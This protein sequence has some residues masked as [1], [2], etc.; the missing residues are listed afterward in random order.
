MVSVLMSSQCMVRFVQPNSN[1]RNKKK[2][3]SNK[4]ALCL[5]KDEVGFQPNEM[6]TRGKYILGALTDVFWMTSL[7]TSSNIS[8]RKP[9]K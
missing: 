3:F 6:E 5:E 9:K 7:M 2:E 1:P 4:V 8:S